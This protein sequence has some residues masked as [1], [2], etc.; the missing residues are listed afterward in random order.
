MF[1]ADLKTSKLRL[2]EAAP[3]GVP[4]LFTPCHGPQRRPNHKLKSP[5][6][7]PPVIIVPSHPLFQ[8]FFFSSSL[9]YSLPPAMPDPCL[10]ILSLPPSFPSLSI[11]VPF[12]LSLPCASFPHNP[13][14]YLYSI[15]TSRPFLSPFTPFLPCLPSLSPPV[16]YFIRHYR[17]HHARLTI[18]LPSHTLLNTSSNSTR[19]GY[20][21]T[22]AHME[23]KYI[24][25]GGIV[26]TENL[27]QSPLLLFPYFSLSLSLTL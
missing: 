19:G 5:S 2:S 26:L 3:P 6:S 1:R 16:Q 14:P 17:L 24:S 15:Y 11:S 12:L 9:H 21:R 23:I 27:M 20:A 25:N 10:L 18:L 7:L 4:T 8:C 13:V 22:T